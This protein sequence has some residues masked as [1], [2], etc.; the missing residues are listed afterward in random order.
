MRYTGRA[1]GLIMA[2]ACALV[3]PVCA[4]Q[5]SGAASNAS[6]AG[7]ND[8]AA[9]GIA[10]SNPTPLS[11]EIRPTVDIPVGQSAQYFA[12]GG[13]LD[14][15]LRYRFGGLPLFAI[16][17]LTY[18]LAPDYG[19]HFSDDVS[20]AVARVG[21]GAFLP[22]SRSIR[23]EAYGTAGYFYGTL[24]DFSVSSTN[25]Y[26]AGGVGVQIVFGPSFRLGIEGLFR[27]YFGLYQGISA[28]IA[29]SFALG[30]HAKPPAAGTTPAVT[31][32]S[33]SAPQL[34]PLSAPVSANA[35]E[36]NAKGN[37]TIGSV[38][39]SPIFPVFYSYYDNH[40]IGSMEIT[41]G[42]S[43]A[44]SN[45]TASVYIKQYMDN[46]KEIDVKGD[47]G[48]SESKTINLYALFT[49]SVLSITEGTKA[50][51][52]ITLDYTSG[53]KQYEDR[54]IETVQFL[55]RNAMT[56]DDNRRPAAY[57]TAKDPAVLTFSKSIV[58]LVRSK[59]VRSINA[60]LQTAMALHEALD[61]YG[62]NYVQD[63]TTPFAVF[64]KKKDAVDFLQFPRQTL[65]YKAGDCDDLSILYS[66]LLE[67]VGIDTAFITTPGHIFVAVDTGLTPK[68]AV[69][70]LIPAD[71]FI[72]HEGKAWIPVEVTLR[73]EGFLKAWEQGAK[74]WN[75]ANPVG[76]A[77]FYPIEEAWKVYSPVGLPGG[78]A[79]IAVPSGDKVLATYLA[80][81]TKYIDQAIFPK[82]AKLQ[83]EI[84][85]TGSLPAMNRLGI[86]YA[87]YGQ[88]AKAKL[89]FSEILTRKK[90]YLP[91]ILNL[92]NLAYLAQDW[93]RA[94]K[95]YQRAS[96]LAPE[97]AHV[98][99]A[100]ARVNQQLEN[101]GNVKRSYAKLQSLDPALADQFAY[102]ALG[103]QAGTTRAADV[104]AQMKEVLWE[105]E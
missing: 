1:A 41:D 79:N 5:P 40:P 105:G 26:A 72:V 58:G 84:R 71:Q 81:V 56:W 21:A 99:L 73:H 100:V 59:E 18:A 67:A 3:G 78:D 23:L 75:E 46:P 83:S 42:G 14:V 43:T 9:A 91:A 51:A 24:N 6:T 92:G 10:A 47:L 62:L 61:L 36:A 76:K 48:P 12:D 70:A 60:S 8:S 65:Q 22:V 69:A 7:V 30:A 104:E 17:G 77:G 25:P 31:R 52:E 16:G 11:L 90:D 37:L 44:D 19:A 38:D 101:Y 103:S 15:N 85:S 63:P 97:N 55:N 29:T 57:V 35:R 50:S 102:L 39:V 80:E 74:E 34:Q 49:E 82:V 27:S 96:E 2:C 32:P 68:K 94:Q 98:L 64:S 95:Y 87:K 86:L 66:S 93:M 13:T 4:Q 20:L 33:P 53:G 88:P 28:A 45:I 54:K 89:E